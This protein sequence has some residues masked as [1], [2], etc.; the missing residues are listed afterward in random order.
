MTPIENWDK[1]GMT[2]F[3]SY[4]VKASF[5]GNSSGYWRPVRTGVYIGGCPA[6]PSNR[7]RAKRVFITT[8]VNVTWWHIAM[9][10]SW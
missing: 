4:R 5:L 9:P 6:S 3:S 10:S 7:S 2:S 8:K 1:P